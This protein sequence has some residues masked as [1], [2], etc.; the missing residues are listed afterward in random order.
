MQSSKPHTQRAANFFFAANFA[1]KSESL[2]N[3]ANEGDKP[4]APENGSSYYAQGLKK[5][6]VKPL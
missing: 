5:S 4:S 2:R 3:L 1:L 6:E